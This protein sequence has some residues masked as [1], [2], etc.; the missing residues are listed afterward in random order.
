[1]R[2]AAPPAYPTNWWAISFIRVA[3]SGLSGSRAE[4]RESAA[5]PWVV[6]LLV[7]RAGAVGHAVGILLCDHEGCAKRP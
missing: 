4:K 7:A 5:M 1:V 2:R 3:A 6:D